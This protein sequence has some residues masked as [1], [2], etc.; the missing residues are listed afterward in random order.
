MKSL[1]RICGLWMRTSKKCTKKKMPKTF[2]RGVESAFYLLVTLNF[3]ISLSSAVLHIFMIFS[4]FSFLFAWQVWLVCTLPHSVHTPSDKLVCD[5]FVKIVWISLNWISSI[6]S[7]FFSSL[8]SVV[9]FE[10]QFWHKNLL[11]L[12]II[13]CAFGSIKTADQN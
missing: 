10:Q 5:N 12:G 9:F 6:D 3:N 4:V 7:V 1:P 2:G 13:F 11:N 8:N